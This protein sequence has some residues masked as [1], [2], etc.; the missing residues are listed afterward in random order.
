MFRLS[1]LTDYAIALLTHMVSDDKSIWAA[2]DLAARSRLPQPTVSKIL[3]HLAKSGLIKALRGAAGGYQLSKSP[4]E[5]SIIQIVEAMDGPIS[6]TDCSGIGRESECLI[7]DFCV[8]G[9]NWNKI[10]HAVR[11][12][13]ASVSLADMAG[14]AAAS[15]S[16]ISK[17]ERAASFA[18]STL[19]NTQD[20]LSSAADGDN[21]GAARQ[22]AI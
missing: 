14:K 7:R 3:K 6:I 13:L 12:A 8:M 1:R 10:N 18:C 15:S 5:I 9:G 20:E 16:I 22:V 17:P 4:F 21:N 19:E 11:S 2:S